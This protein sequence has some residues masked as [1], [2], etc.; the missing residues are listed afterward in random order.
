M[1]R[2][3]LINKISKYH[4]TFSNKI[5]KILHSCAISVSF[6]SECCFLEKEGRC[7]LVTVA[8]TI[9]NNAQILPMKSLKT[10]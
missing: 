3:H 7:N 2:T 6:K 8:Y 9:V 1:N 5:M 10:K 4:E